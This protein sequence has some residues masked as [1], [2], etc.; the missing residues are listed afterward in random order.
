MWR[1]CDDDAPEG[2]DVAWG[3]YGMKN[4]PLLHLA[5]FSCCCTDT[6]TAGKYIHTEL[7]LQNNIL[8]L[9]KQ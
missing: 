7:F 6:L 1:D 5:P 9:K 2:A 3:F 4:Y 8:G